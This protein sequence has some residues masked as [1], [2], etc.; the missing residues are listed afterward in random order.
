M[1][2]YE[3]CGDKECVILSAQ[4]ATVLH[5]YELVLWLSHKLRISSSRLL[6]GHT[7]HREWSRDKRVNVKPQAHATHQTNHSTDVIHFP[8]FLLENSS[9]FF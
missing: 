1:L 4:R 3:L 6:L 5:A 8:A 7:I 2:L 9:F